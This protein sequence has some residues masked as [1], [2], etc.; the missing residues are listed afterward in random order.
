MHRRPLSFDDSSER[1]GRNLAVWRLQWAGLAGLL[2]SGLLWTGLMS[3][4]L[5]GQSAVGADLEAEYRETIRP[6]LATYCYDCHAEGAEEGG[7]SLDDGES[8]T[9]LLS[10]RRRCVGR[11]E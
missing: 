8:A 3:S 10:D 1:R 2:W 4:L 9:D 6:I 7:M 11:V 5:P